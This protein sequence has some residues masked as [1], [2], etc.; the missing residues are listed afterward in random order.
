MEQITWRF[1]FGAM[2]LLLLF[3]VPPSA[4]GSSA[5]EALGNLSRLKNLTECCVTRAGY[6]RAYGQSAKKVESFLRDRQADSLSAQAKA[7]GKVWGHYE[8][9]ARI[10]ERYATR[11]ICKESLLVSI[12]AAYPSA[13]RD[14]DQGGAM[15][16]S[17]AGKKCMAPQLLVP[18]IFRR[19]AKALK[20]AQDILGQPDTNN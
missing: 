4:Q 8:N 7:V 15:M 2:F 20:H 9:A 13:G 3:A 5:R 10:Y 1:L 6:L 14:F 19:A 11:L 17:P 12:K 16:L 18:I